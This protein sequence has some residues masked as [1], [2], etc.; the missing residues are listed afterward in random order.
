MKKIILLSSLAIG[1]LAMQ[2]QVSPSISSWLRNTTG[3]TGRHYAKGNS[4]PIVDNALANV[5]TVQYSTNWV[6]INT[7]GIP[8]YITGPFLDNN[9]SVATAQNAI[10]KFPLVPVKNS[11]TPTATMLGNIGIFINGVALFDY[12]DGVSWSNSSNAL[13]GG[14]L[15]GMGDNVWNR[16]AIVAER[17]GFDCAKAHPAMGNYH[18]HQ[19]PSAFS[20][21]L[22]VI[23][24]VCTLYA[25]DGLYA[26]DSTKH[27]PLIGFAY[28]GFPIY[29]AY[30]YKN[31]D[32][33]GG[34]VRMKSSYSL[35][36]ITTRTT[37]ADGS[38]VTAGPAVDVT[39][40]LGYFREDYQYNTTSTSTP[41]LLDE[42]N[43]RFC[44]TPEYPN[45]TYCYFATVDENWN[46]AYPYVVG[47]TFYGNVTAAKVTS[48]SEATTIYAPT[49]T[50]VSVVSKDNNIQIYPNPASDLVAV[51]LGNL[52]KE[53]IQVEL[54][55]IT[56]K[57]IQ[58]TTLYQ[59]STIVYFDTQTLYN[60][61]YIIRLIFIFYIFQSNIII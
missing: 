15:K 22:K 17:A 4:T 35:R 6:Y 39:Y 24:T 30:G 3:I 50:G 60:G 25:A 40:P 38:T 44:I 28:D 41:D 45:G 42:H 33:T 32:G 5:Q 11:G 58:R 61:E 16:D 47:P 49:N 34:I 9:P 10:F 18:H 13:K 26:I 21:D 12:R 7:N 55:D 51:Q 2:A 23:S 36:N 20:L 31:A 37:Y 56:G 19:N 54:F 57:S 27:S 46:S 8:A 59:G 48:I 43:G 29:G 1:A 14:P 52:A 53:N